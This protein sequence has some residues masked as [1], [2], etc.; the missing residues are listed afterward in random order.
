MHYA[1]RNGYKSIVR[2]LLF[3]DSSLATKK[4]KKGKTPADIGN[5][6]I[7]MLIRKVVPLLNDEKALL[8]VV[9]DVDMRYLVP[10]FISSLAP[11]DVKNSEGKMPYELVEDED[12]KTLLCPHDRDNHRNNF[13]AVKDRAQKY[14]SEFEMIK[15]M[16]K[17]SHKER[18]SS[19]EVFEFAKKI[20]ERTLAGDHVE[21]PAPESSTLPSN[22]QE[23]EEDSLD[24]KGRLEEGKSHDI[25]RNMFFGLM[26]DA[27]FEGP[28]FA[29][30][31]RT[32]G[33]ALEP[34]HLNE[35]SDEQK[36]GKQ[37]LNKLHHVLVAPFL[38]WTHRGTSVAS[39]GFRI[40]RSSSDNSWT[41]LKETIASSIELE[42]E[43]IV[44]GSCFSTKTILDEPTAGVQPLLRQ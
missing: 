41:S 8:D 42:A 38:L 34:R 2:H 30:E 20:Q 37:D 36:D 14:P 11:I 44:S 26:K 27:S 17:V 33:S 6:D 28:S 43:T 3:N 16:L 1:S 31:L 4:N 29:R 39:T 40:G 32:Q 12:L 10:D 35:A 9:I 5:K 25:Q 13:D 7:K 22:L 18:P 24:L 23:E 15:R 21:V 19:A